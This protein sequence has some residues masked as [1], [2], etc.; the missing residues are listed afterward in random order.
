MTRNEIAILKNRQIPWFFWGK[1]EGYKAVSILAVNENGMHAA[2][3]CTRV[4]MLLFLARN[5]TPLCA[6][7]FS[8]IPYLE[9]SHYFAVPLLEYKLVAHCRNLQR[10]VSEYKS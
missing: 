6:S 10:E 3:N 7:P 8:K 1:Q 2:S 4:F 5:G 9:K